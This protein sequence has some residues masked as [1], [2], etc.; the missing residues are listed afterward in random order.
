MARPGDQTV[1]DELHW[2]GLVA[3][4]TDEDALRAALAQG[5]VTYYVGFDPTAPSLHHGNL[6]QLV[7]A[8]RFQQAGHTPLLLIGGS[9][10]LIGDPKPDAERT[11]NDP[12]TVAGWVERLKRQVEPFVSFEGPNAA[13]IVNN[14]DWTAPVSILTF[15]RD[16]GRH[17][18]VNKMIQKEVVK[19]RLES[20][21]GIGYAEFS[22]QILQAFDYLELYRRYGCTLQTGGSDQWGNIT[23]GVDLIRRA[24]GATVHALATPLL[25]RSD[26]TKF[27]K[28]AGGLTVWLDPEMM[29][30]YAFYQFWF[31]TADA[32]VAQYLRVFSFRSREELEELEK[33]TAER[34]AAREAQRVLAEELTTLV[35][36]Q[37]ETV[38]VIAASAALFGRGT[39]GEID[40]RTLDAALREAPHV[41]VEVAGGTPLPS[42]ADLLADA[43]LVQSRSAARRTIEEGGA[44]L[45]NERVTDVDAV[46]TA[47]DLLHGRWLVLRRGRRSMAGVEVAAG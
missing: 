44:Y 6:V 20:D 25:T 35:H 32:D 23:A 34:P 45:N 17:F 7:T 12:E 33:T 26:G 15:L 5:P 43:G 2:R 9:T 3:E 16:I 22:Y 41:R 11:L 40:A 36:G 30:P 39:L 19:T 1:L 21:A 18:R 4:A 14:L 10:G 24:E 28:S 8:R 13:R 27:G 42:V 46:P 38:R 37:E 29:S 31:N 47:G